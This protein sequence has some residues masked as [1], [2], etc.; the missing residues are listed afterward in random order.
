MNCP[1]L[2]IAA[3]GNAST[4]PD[5]THLMPRHRRPNTERFPGTFALARLE[6][7]AAEPIAEELPAGTQ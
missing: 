6:S 5:A 1:F 4:G 3:P 2:A 7:A